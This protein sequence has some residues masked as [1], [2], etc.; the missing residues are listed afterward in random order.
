[1][2]MKAGGSGTESIK[3][4]QAWSVVSTGLCVCV[5]VCGGGGGG[6]CHNGH[7]QQAR[8]HG[9]VRSERHGRCIRGC[10]CRVECRPCGSVP[11]HPNA[12][13]V[14]HFALYAAC[15]QCHAH[16]GTELS[17]EE[18]Q[19]QKGGNLLPCQIEGSQVLVITWLCSTWRESTIAV[20]KDECDCRCVVMPT[21][22]FCWGLTSQ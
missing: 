14:H 7:G 3:H 9:S 8:Q 6:T 10:V 1:M 12:D 17:D 15:L 16:T 4:T 5:C 2:S 18:T 22:P 13:A 19:R 21:F 20:K 11:H